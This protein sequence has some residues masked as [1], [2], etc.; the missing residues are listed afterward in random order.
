N[1]LA[2]NTDCAGQAFLHSTQG[3]VKHPNFVAGCHL[4]ALRK[5]TIGN[6]VKMLTGLNQLTHHSA[7]KDKA[8][9]HHQQETD[10]YRDTHGGQGAAQRFVSCLEKLRANLTLLRVEIVH[11]ALEAF[12]TRD[13]ELIVLEIKS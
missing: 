6:A 2:N 3:G 8:D 10:E 4:H 5:I 7:A 13:A 12:R 9:R 11:S 1:T